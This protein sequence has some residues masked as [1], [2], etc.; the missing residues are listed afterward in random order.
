LGGCSSKNLSSVN[1]TYVSSKLD[2]PFMAPRSELCA[3]S[4]IEMLSLYWHSQTQTVPR[5]T[6]EELDSR[7]L[8]PQKGG[9]LQIELMAAARANGFAVYVLE[10]NFEALTLEL[11]ASHPVIVLVNR[12]L[13]WVPLWH[14]VPVT[15]YDAQTQ[16]ILTHF[17]NEANEAIAMKTFEAIWQRA[18]NWGVVLLPPGEIPATA[19]PEKFLLCVYELEKSGMRKEAVVSYEAAL[20]RWP[21][22]V[23]ILFALGNAYYSLG[24]I[25]AAQKMYARVVSLDAANPLALNNLADIAFHRGEFKEARELLERAKTEDA[26]IQSLLN[27]TREEIE[28][29]STSSSFKSF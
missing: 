6:L 20:K 28:K 18:G 15:G 9:T 21:Q 25:D 29:A 2:V 4:S 1:K 14:Y 8:I 19:T 22:N 16:T 13:A 10:P 17:G 23:N 24:Q 26:A 27:A 7:T 12:S 11:S 5:L 3:S